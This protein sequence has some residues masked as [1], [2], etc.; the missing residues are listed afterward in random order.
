VRQVIERTA[1][2]DT[3]DGVMIDISPGAYGNNSL[4]QNDGRGHPVNPATGQPYAPERVKR[5]DFARVLAEF[6]ADG[7]LSETPPGHWN[8]IANYVADHAAFKRRWRGQGDELDRL[9]WDVRLYLALN[10]A[11]H[12]AAITAWGI[13]R[14][15]TGPRPISLVRYM[16][17]LGQSTDTSLPSYHEHGLPLVPGLIELISAESA[18]AGER[19]AHLARY[20]GE[21]AV[22]SYRGEPGDRK[23]EIGGVGWIRAVEW[24]PYQRRTFVTPAFPGFISGHSTF[25]R[26]SAEVLAAATGSAF[27]PAGL[28]EYVAEKNAYLTF[29][30]GPSSHVRLQWGTYYDAADQAGQSRVYGGIHIQPDDLLGRRLG[31]RVGLDALTRAETFFSGD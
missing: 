8:T 15:F 28:G 13:K 11:V 10:G 20:L 29:E 2:L 16:A 4:G 14:R 25:S 18:Q 22:R 9:A 23:N 31:S 12:D 30:K 5:G 19:H 6:W 17:A 1:A 26:A 27:F 24:I 21:I 7:P 3:E